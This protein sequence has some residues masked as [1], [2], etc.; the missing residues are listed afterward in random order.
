MQRCFSLGL[1]MTAALVLATPGLA[2]EAKTEAKPAAKELAPAEQENA[3]KLV[4]KLGDTSFVVRET[5]TQQLEDLGKPALKVLEDGLKSDDMEVRRRCKH[6]VELASRTDMEI[7]LDAFLNDKNDKLI[8]ALP[9]WTRFSKVIGED[10]PAKSLFVDMYCSEST[11]LET[12]EK[13]PKNFA[14]R[15]NARCQDIQREMY[16]PPYTGQPKITMGQVLALLFVATDERAKLDTNAFYMVTNFFYQPTIQEQFKKDGGARKLLA[17]FI[18][19]RSD[20]NTLP[21][22]LQIAQQLDLKEAVPVALKAL[23]DDGKQQQPYTK[24]TAALLVGKLGGAEQIPALEGLLNDKTNLGAM[25]INVNQANQQ[26]NTEMRD[27]ALAAMIQ[28]SGEDPFNYDFPYLKLIA[29]NWRGNVNVNKA[30]YYMVPQYYGFPDE[31]ARTAVLDKWKENQA[32]KKKDEGKK[33]EGK[34]E[35]PKK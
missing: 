19:T 29:Q 30:G 10:K 16:A 15:F 17:E 1:A 22:A 34:K 2:E 11:L 4:A 14:T 35:E 23:K 27:V 24:A 20:N 31:K 18:T 12:L 3:R 26:I 7:A 8:L 9:T 32:A 5:A 25:T 33:G 13:D 28:A 21:N 6:L